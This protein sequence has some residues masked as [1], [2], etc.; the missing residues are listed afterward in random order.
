MSARSQLCQALGVMEKNE[1]ACILTVLPLLLI[2]AINYSIIG[3]T[4]VKCIGTVAT[5]NHQLLVHRILSP[6]NLT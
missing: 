6:I 1:L 5:E 3:I 2:K 4:G